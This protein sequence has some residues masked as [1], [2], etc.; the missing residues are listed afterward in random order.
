MDARIDGFVSSEEELAEVLKSASAQKV[1]AVDT[2][3]DSLHRY[4]E[5]L[6][7]IQFAWDDQSVLIDPLAVQDLKLLVDYMRDREVWMHGADYD[8]TMLRR[9]FDALPGD[10]FD[11]QIGVRLLGLRQ[12]GLANLVEHYFDVKLSK[13]SQKADWGKRPL[14]EKMIEY[15]LNDVRYLL[16]MAEKI[17]EELK[18]LG[19]YEWFVESCEVAKERVLE[20]DETKDDPWRIQG[21][22][23]LDR[24]GLHFLN[25]LWYWRDKEAMRWDRPT[26][27]VATNRQLIDWAQV[28]ADDKRLELPHHYR[29]DRRRRFEAMVKDAREV[30]K[31]HYPHR[32]RGLRRRRDKDFDSRLDELL[33]RRNSVAEDLGIEGSVIASRGMLE[34]LAA[35]DEGAVDAFMNWQRQCLDLG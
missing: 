9:E 20:R 10:V 35:R 31:E 18:E 7:L 21:S 24:A 30:S 14:S 11:T 23:R 29:P 33:K 25:A 5:S 17:V 6:C 22:G 26:F 15:A 12:F 3:A 8:M 28:L 27:M 32:L 13:S 34:A 4:R 19:R 2:E 1:C 16:P